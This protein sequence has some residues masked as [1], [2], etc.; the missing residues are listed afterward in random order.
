MLALVCT[1]CGQKNTQRNTQKKAEPDNGH[2]MRRTGN[3]DVV[4]MYLPFGDDDDDYVFADMEHQTLFYAEIP[5]DYL[6][7]ENGRELSDDDLHKGDIVEVYNNGIVL[8]M[9]PPK[10][11]GV[12]KMVRVKKGTDE[13]AKKYEHLIAEIYSEPDTDEI[14]YLDI[15]N[16]QETAVVTSAVNHGGYSW[17]YKDGNAVQADSLHVL[18]WKRS[19]KELVELN[20]DTHD[21][22]L[23]L[24]FSRRPKSVKVTRWDST[25]TMEDVDKGEA[26]RVELD[27]REAEID[28]AKTDSIYEVVAEWEQG[29]VIYGFAVK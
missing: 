6:L 8:E 19:D 14:P 22:D 5:D 13:D 3:A 27:G 20:C 11:S 12:T 28:D 24:M 26:V 23:K 1:G 16:K 2:K 4:G 21:K 7:D 15:E 17:S 29:T 25:A 10:Y 18:Q 9:Y